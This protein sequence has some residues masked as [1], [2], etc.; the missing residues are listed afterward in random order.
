MSRRSASLRQN[1]F[2]D[3]YDPYSSHDGCDTTYT[4][5]SAG[6]TS[7]RSGRYLGL[8]GDDEFQNEPNK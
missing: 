4:D 8:L 5:V 6:S 2:E 1:G 3:R 7:V